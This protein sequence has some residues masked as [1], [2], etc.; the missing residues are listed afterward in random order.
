MATM[1][2][3]RGR[4][5]AR[6][7]SIAKPSGSV[8]P[9]VQAASP[10]R[11]GILA[12]D[13]AKHR[14]KWMLANF[15][16]KI[17]V[18]PTLVE[19]TRPGLD[20]AIVAAREAIARHNLV[21]QIVAIE[22]TGN[23]HLPV[24]RAFANAGFDTR[25]VH[26]L[27]TKQFR[28][29][30]DPS[31]KTDDTDLFAIHLAAAN[32]FGLIEQAIG[33]TYGELRLLARHRRELVRKNADSRNQIH[34]QLDALLPGLSTAVG[35]IFD[36]EPA[37]VI[38]RR[39][40]SARAIL[41]LGIEGLE[42]LLHEQGVRSQRRSL[43]KILAWAKDADESMGCSQVH[44]R[45]LGD[46]DDERRA[47]LRVIEGLEREMAGYLAR[48]P[49][50]LLLSIP[51]IN[52]VTAAEFAG[53]MGPIENYPSDSS[54][55]GRAGLFPSRY[56]S[57]KVDHSDGPLV[58]RANHT[59]RY[60]LLLIADNLLMC[61]AYF[62]GLRK[63]WQAAGVDPRVQCVRAGKRFSRIAYRMVAGREVYRHPSCQSRHKILHKLTLFH[64]KHAT[65]AEI[66]RRDLIAAADWIP[67]AEH[68]VEAEPL[69]AA[70]V[71]PK[72]PVA[73]CQATS[74]RRTGPAPLSTILPDVLLRLG[75][76][77]V[78][79]T[80]KGETDPT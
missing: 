71:P 29:P 58:R 51:G 20:D 60:V 40:G 67:T 73:P 43:E 16:G 49:Y 44:L 23:Y 72:R 52:I 41:A 57:D 33:E 19:H 31:I 56:Q 62:K 80:P 3:K 5:K 61:N 53:E 4:R 30:A 26:P 75:V 13:C 37:L 11:F 46:L 48:T 66:L 27:T 18:P 42:R 24:R 21:D 59:L 63:K 25:I 17:L 9:R 2:R 70:A 47:R 78:Q 50:V 65:T 38:A 79:S 35:G 14:S 10:E 36:N 22:R 1:T 54:I 15:Y 39:T 55:T 34:V 12:V 69:K 77:M 8:H 76:R 64:F 7:V 45:I 68:A 28:L 6:F 74:E 32:G